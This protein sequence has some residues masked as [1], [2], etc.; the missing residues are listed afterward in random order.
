MPRL[1]GAHQPF[2]AGGR[3]E[4]ET[5]SSQERGLDWARM[6]PY[7]RLLEAGG[8]NVTF[9]GARCGDGCPSDMQIKL[10]GASGEMRRRIW[11]LVGSYFHPFGH[12]VDV[13]MDARRLELREELR[14]AVRGLRK[15][16]QA[17]DPELKV[18][19]AKQAL[20]LLAQIVVAS[21][22]LNQHAEP[23]QHAEVRLAEALGLVETA[24][25]R[26]LMAWVF[27]E[28]NSLTPPGSCYARV[29][30]LFARLNRTLDIHTSR[31]QRAR[32]AFALLGIL[33][34][35][36]TVVALL[37]APSNLARG[38]L[39]SASSV[40]PLTPPQPLGMPRLARAVDGRHDEATFALC[41]QPE[42]GPWVL[43]DLRRNQRV[44]E[45]VVFPRNEGWW[46]MQFGPMALQ[47]SNDGT[48]F[49][50]V[51]AI[52]RPVLAGSA[53]RVRLRPTH[54][55]F[56]R[57]AGTGQNPQAIFLSELE[58]NGYQQ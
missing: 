10:P 54:A 2:S 14:G 36:T 45:I 22:K 49:Q 58:V 18:G 55:R 7:A 46:N 23:L 38:A 48:R 30:H 12:P 4:D 19:L 31:E 57:V 51:A 40:C 21:R 28:R 11:N 25:D 9:G 52:D 8:S 24:A 47:L 53:W 1:R 20:R 6:V 32:A 42:S 33:A 44:T 3:A 43:V 16:E 15:A 27:D 29:V 35:S 50:T 13:W 34:L 26:S 41:T 56:V 37:L 39:V 17:T 5:A